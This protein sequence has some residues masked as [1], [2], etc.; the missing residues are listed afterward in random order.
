MQLRNMHNSQSVPCNKDYKKQL[1]KKTSE[2][3][4]SYYNTYDTH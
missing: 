1:I 3:I 4:T 2:F